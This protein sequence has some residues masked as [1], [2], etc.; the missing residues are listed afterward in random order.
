VGARII[1]EENLPAGLADHPERQ[2]PI[3]LDGQPV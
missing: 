1:T 3:L 2:F